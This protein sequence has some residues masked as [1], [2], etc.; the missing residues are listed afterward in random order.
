M[1][2]GMKAVRLHGYNQRLVLED[3]PVPDVEQAEVHRVVIKYA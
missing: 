3:I 2:E 1:M